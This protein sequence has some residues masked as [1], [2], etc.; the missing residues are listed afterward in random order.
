MAAVQKKKTK[1]VLNRY[2]GTNSVSIPKNPGH[3]FSETLVHVDNNVN[4]LNLYFPFF[5]T[6]FDFV[7]KLFWCNE[8][9]ACLIS[10]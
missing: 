3:G 7:K 2:L 4:F 1:M 8:E 5:L 6:A 10:Y 9:S